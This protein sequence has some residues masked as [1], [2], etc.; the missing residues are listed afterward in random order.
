MQEMKSQKLT[1]YLEQKLK[2]LKLVLE[3]ETVAAVY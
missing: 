1:N 2:P 3:V